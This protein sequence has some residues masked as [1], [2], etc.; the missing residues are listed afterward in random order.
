VPTALYEPSTLVT[1]FL[2][3]P[4]VACKEQNTVYDCDAMATR[5]DWLT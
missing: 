2:P 3:V 5:R 1:Y 4:N